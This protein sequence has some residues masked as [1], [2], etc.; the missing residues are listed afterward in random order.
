MFWCFFCCLLCLFKCFY[1]LF[2]GTVCLRSMWLCYFTFFC[3][4]FINYFV[5][6]LCYVFVFYRYHVLNALS[7][8]RLQAGV[9]FFITFSFSGTTLVLKDI[10]ISYFELINY[11]LWLLCNDLDDPSLSI[12]WMVMFQIIYQLFAL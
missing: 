1:F 8:S 10:Y 5:F 9:L 4:V 3:Y 2:K 11:P 6:I 7:K 12:T